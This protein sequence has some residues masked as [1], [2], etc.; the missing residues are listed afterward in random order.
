MKAFQTLSNTRKLPAMFLLMII[1]TAGNLS[2][3]FAHGGEDHGE[4]KPK[5]TESTKGTISHTARIGDLEVMLKHPTLA[6]DAATDARLFITR[7]ETNEALAGVNLALEIEAAN[8]ATTP[9]TVEKT[10]PPGSFNVKFPA[11]P[12]GI[13]MIRANLT[14]G[15]ETDTVTFSGVQV[16]NAPTASAENGAAWLS[17]VLLYLIGAVVLGLFGILFYF[18][19]RMADDKQVADETVSA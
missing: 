9:A 10:E 11:L 15:G 8:G 19:W 6:P 3:I 5:T 17:S 18:V 1:F 13:Y 7:F 14:Y 4:A 2:Q 16:Q 12:Q